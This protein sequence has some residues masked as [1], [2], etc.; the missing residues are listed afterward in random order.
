MALIRDIHPD[1][2]AALSGPFHPVV[3]LHADWPG[4]AVRVHSGVGTLHWDG[5]AWDGIGAAGALRLPEEAT[6]LA[7]IGGSMRIGGLPAEIDA[8][9][10]ADPTGRDVEVWFG[11]V[12]ER[13]GTVLIGAP[14]AAYVAYVDGMEDETA[15][16]PDGLVRTIEIGISS[17]PPQRTAF[18]A[19]HSYEDQITAHPGDTA[20]RWVKAAVSRTAVELP[21]W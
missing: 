12:T 17:T 6:G 19:H 21:K 13:A 8:H 16:G 14:F 11:A 9:L 15:P 1:L 3:L 18:A 10:A 7:A 20:G 5:H 4:G 2:F